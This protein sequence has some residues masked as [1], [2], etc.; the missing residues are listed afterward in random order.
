MKEAEKAIGQGEVSHHPGQYVELDVDDAP[1]PADLLP[2]ISLPINRRHPQRQDFR[3][4]DT[5]ASGWLDS[6]V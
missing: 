2:E 5:P 1:N 3:Q 4:I 6:G